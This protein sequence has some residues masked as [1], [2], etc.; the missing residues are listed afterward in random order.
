MQNIIAKEVEALIFI[1]GGGLSVQEMAKGLSAEVKDVQ[2]ALECLKNKY[3][4]NQSGIILHKQGNKYMLATSSEM[5]SVIHS[6]VKEKKKQHLT[7]ASLEALAIIAY[8]QPITLFEIE[9]IRGV[10]SRSL[11]HI[12]LTRKFICVSGQKAIPGKPS[13]YST[14]QLFLK[15]FGL[16]NLTFLPDIEEI[17][18]LNF[19][20]LD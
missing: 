6:M 18:T 20:E 10:S 9:E 13:L 19:D 12:L 5:S 2:D 11:I 15:Q 8:K 16:K 17:K 4:V 7:K 1:S 3:N 14:T